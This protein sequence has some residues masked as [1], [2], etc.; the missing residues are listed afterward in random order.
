[1]PLSQKPQTISEIVESTSYLQ[2]QLLHHPQDFQV[3]YVDQ[4]S[5]IEFSVP[6]SL[7]KFGT[8]YS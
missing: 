7:L 1:M 3:F 6:G 2:I 5:N 8:C 4:Y